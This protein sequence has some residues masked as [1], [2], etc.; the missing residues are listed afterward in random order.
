MVIATVK[1]ANFRSVIDFCVKSNKLKYCFILFYKIDEFMVLEKALIQNHPKTNKD[2][3]I[4]CRKWRRLRRNK[5]SFS[6]QMYF[7]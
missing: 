2:L 4:I 6:L 5:Y 3:I 7:F 1:P